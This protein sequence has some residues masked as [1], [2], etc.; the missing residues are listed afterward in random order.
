MEK[1]L[2]A[3]DAMN[4][5]THAI[6]FGCY[7]AKL[8]H[9]RLTGVFL[10]GL[11]EERPMVLVDVEGQHQV[12]GNIRH[13]REACVCRDTLSLV[14]RDRAVP[15]DEI[16]AES[17]FADLLIVDPEMAFNRK[18][19]VVRGHFVKDVLRSAECPVLIAPY[20]FDCIEE[21]VFAYDGSASSV[22][23]IRQF[24]HLFP[25]LQMTPLVVISIREDESPAI[26][27]QFKMKEWLE[28]HYEHL[29]FEVR[30]GGGAA[31]QLL[32]YLIEKKNTM[33]VMGA[34]GRSEVSNFFRPSRAETL[35]KTVNL[36]IFITHQ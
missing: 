28:A 23:A 12:E 4:I 34:Y 19:T 31:G 9:S 8:T 18:D 14:H 6:D 22:F 2:L 36:P 11:G 24:A 7:I 17:R 21:I 16:L 27:E 30:K 3:L 10:E 13:F 32:A 1:I 26:E 5:N 35:I 15:L 33:L 29:H 20:S 25:A